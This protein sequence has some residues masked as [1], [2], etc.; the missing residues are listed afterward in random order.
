MGIPMVYVECKECGYC[1]D[2]TEHLWLTLG[3]KICPKCG[4]DALEQIL[5]EDTK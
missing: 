1:T 5:E 2:Y 4:E 3:K